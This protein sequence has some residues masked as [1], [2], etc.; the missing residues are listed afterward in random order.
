MSDAIFLAIAGAFF[1]LTALYVRLCDYM[2]GPDEVAGNV[3]PESATTNAV[4]P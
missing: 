4:L 2:I 3:D 1:V